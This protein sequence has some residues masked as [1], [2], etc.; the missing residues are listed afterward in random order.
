MAAELSIV[1]PVHNA[2]S[3]LAECLDSISAQ[4]LGRYE[5]IVIDDG[6]SDNSAAIIQRYQKT[7]NRIQ[8]VQPGRIGLVESLNLGIK[9][10]RTRTIARMDADDI[11][12]PDR[13]GKQMSYLATNPDVGLVSCLVRL[14]PDHIIKK[15]YQEYI[16]WQN[17]V[18]TPEQIATQIYVESP[19]AHPSVMFRKSIIGA[20][21]GY[22]YGDFPE[23]Y[24]L[25]LR[26][27]SNGIRMTKLDEVLLEWRDSAQRASRTDP[28]Y[29][30]LSFDRLRAE[31][32]GRDE[33]IPKNRPLV[34]WGAGRKT[35]QRAQLLIEKGF[36]VCAWIDIDPNKIGNRINGI[37]VH[38]PQ[39][40]EQETRP[41]VLNYVNN[42]GAREVI[43][44]HLR[45][46][47]YKQNQDYL[48][49]G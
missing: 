29:L 17:S 10:A 30:K 44:K 1:L 35:R 45:G 4:T 32:L 8:L 12:H 14:F 47:G 23:D 16:Q 34:Y 19:F 15:G 26:M 42:Y 22:R 18:T 38:P 46:F 48:M 31:F 41:F 7:D 49:V 5:L 27:I 33:R 11:M 2:E 6:S 9:T 36:P 24:E 28:R 13:L 20:L 21:G 3:T 40:L 25:W 43:A 39:W 37:P